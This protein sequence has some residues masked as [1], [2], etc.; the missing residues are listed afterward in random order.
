MDLRLAGKRA[1][2][3]GASKG[4]GMAVARC[5][6][7]EGCHLHLSARNAAPM[8]AAKAALEA[9]HGITVAV[10]ALDL[11]ST[12][13]MEQLAAKAGHIDILVNNAGDIPAGNLDIVDDERPARPPPAA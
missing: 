9:A 11:S 12:A 5:L 10:D 6:A 4:I 7:A 2:V 8:L 13:A 1:L 3:T